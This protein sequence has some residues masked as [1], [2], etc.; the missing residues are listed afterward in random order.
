MAS[1]QHYC[2]RHHRPAVASRVRILPDGTR[3][4]EYLCDIDLAEERMSRRFG[5]SGLFD[6]FFSDFFGSGGGG[7]TRV[8]PPHPQVSRGARRPFFSDPAPPAPRGAAASAWPRRSARS[9]A[10]T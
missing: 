3:Q 10:W 2:D 7:D 8:A 1:E 5:G 9:S 6:D 4:T